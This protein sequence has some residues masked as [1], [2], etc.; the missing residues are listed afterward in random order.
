MN[1]RGYAATR[2]CPPLRPSPGVEALG[3]EEEFKVVATRRRLELGFQQIDISQSDFDRSID[4]M[5][6]L[7]Q[8]GMHRGASLP[9]LV[10]AA[11]AERTGMILIHYDHHFDNIALVAKQA[12]MSVV[13][14][15]SVP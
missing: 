8:A 12:T 4:V 9:D 3:T 2:A 14:A 1:T 13:P 5:E 6:L 11:V 15:G 10:L 7:A